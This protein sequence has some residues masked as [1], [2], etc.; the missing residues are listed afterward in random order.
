[1]EIKLN[2]PTKTLLALGLALAPAFATAAFPDKPIQIIV[3]FSPGA[4]SDT[5]ARLVAAKM[6]QSLGQAVIVENRPGAA[7]MIGA[8]YIAKSAPDGYHILLGSNSTNAINKSLYRSMTY[9]LETDF[10][11]ISMAG[12]IPSVLIARE[13]L[14]VKTLADLLA[15]G[16][17]K[18]GTLSFANGNTTGQIAG[19]ILNHQVPGLDMVNVPYKSEPLGINDVLGGQADLMFLNL[20]VAYP[21]I[22]A[23]KVRALA[24]PGASAVR[25]LP[26]VPTASQ[27]VPGYTIPNGWLAFFAPAGTPA[28]VVGKLNRAIVAA[29][30][31]ADVAQNLESSG[32][33][34]VRSSSPDELGQIVKQDVATWARFIK[35]ADIPLQ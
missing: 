15:Y 18:P 31:S 1:L 26:E 25:A 12:E 19:L 9:D 27:T 23:G 33:Y 2:L 3:P 6:Q 17:R 5:A 8:A 16:K 22:K 29:L 34:I 14:P 32:G 24:L 21:H 10:A 28:D 4:I 30:Q 20:P 7:G 13:G 11:P 35:E